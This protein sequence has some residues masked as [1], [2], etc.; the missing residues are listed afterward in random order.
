M[1]NRRQVGRSEAEATETQYYLSV[2]EA[3][4]RCRSMR[5]PSESITKANKYILQFRDEYSQSERTAAEIKP[6][7]SRI[8]NSVGDI[9]SATKDELEQCNKALEQLTALI[10]FK[11]S[12]AVSTSRPSSG[13][14]EKRNKRL[15][16][17]GSGAPSS[18]SSAP[19]PLQPPTASSHAPQGITG[20]AAG[21]GS[22]L[23]LVLPA[24][25]ANAIS[26]KYSRH[27]PLAPGRKV[28]FKVPPVEDHGGEAGEEGGWILAVVQKVEK[29][30]RSYHVQDIEGE[31]GSAPLIYTTTARSLIPLPDPK[32]QPNSAAHPSQYPELSKGTVVLALYPDTTAF[33]RAE[34]AATPRDTLVAGLRTAP[35]VARAPGP[36]HVKFDDDDDE[37]RDVTADM[38]V[39]FPE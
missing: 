33:Y 15:L 4:L 9:R 11:S 24:R 16:R 14:V 23:S 31:E 10:A 8:K 22:G 36:Y 21:N 38:L 37:L 32:A 6:V 30:N 28:A 7:K 3:L 13:V 26:A 2:H 18:G 35:Q 5:D 39:E 20:S 27:F 17:P 1:A 29:G 19:L 25:D 12:S 34:V